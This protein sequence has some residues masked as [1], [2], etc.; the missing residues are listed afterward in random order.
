MGT[1]HGPSWC[2]A[3]SPSDGGGLSVTGAAHQ[4][5]LS[6][7]QTQGFLWRAWVVRRPCPPSCL[8]TS[9]SPPFL[10]IWA[11]PGPAWRPSAGGQ[12]SVMHWR[13]SDKGKGTLFQIHFYRN[14]A[15]EERLPPSRQT[16]SPVLSIHVYPESAQ[17]AIKGVASHSPAPWAPEGDLRQVVLCCVLAFPSVF[18][19][20]Q[21]TGGCQWAPTQCLA[22]AVCLTAVGGGGDVPGDL[23]VKDG[24]WG[25]F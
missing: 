8:G 4:A 24:F 6:L 2:W 14:G 12:E 9:P 25:L 22:R 11:S 7:A 23:G 21:N 18:W 5:F 16:N 17:A 15:F 13:A 20:R 19:G 1:F 3:A 10:T